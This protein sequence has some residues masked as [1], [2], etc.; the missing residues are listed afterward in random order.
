M[1]DSAISA[2]VLRFCFISSPSVGA[3]LQSRDAVATRTCERVLGARRFHVSVS[4]RFFGA[5]LCT[6]T[7]VVD[8]RGW[9]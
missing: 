2:K 4:L 6:N 7:T 1:H 3:L 8:S 9:F 5:K